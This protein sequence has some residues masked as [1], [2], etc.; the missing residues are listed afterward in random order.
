MSSFLFILRNLAAWGSFWILMVIFFEGFLQ[1][2]PNWV[3]GLAV[4]GT[5]IY[6]AIC[7]FSHTRRVKLIADRLDA[8]TLASRHRRR[9]EIPLPA[10][11]AFALVEAAIRELPYVENVEAASDSLQ[12]SAQLKRRNPYL[13][14]KHGP[15]RLGGAEGARKNLILAT[16]TP[17]ETVSSLT[18]ICEPEGGAWLDWFM[19]DDG[20]NLENAEAITRALSR[21]IAEHRKGEQAA[22]RETASEKELAVAKLNV[23]NSQFEP[24]FLYNTLASAQILT[25]SDPARADE[26]L[27]NLI[28][29]LRNSMPRTEGEMSTLALELERARAYLEIMRIRMGERLAVQIQVPEALRATPMPP[30]ML[31]TLV[32]N[33]IKHG[34][35]PLTGGG[36]VWIIA[37][38]ADGKVSVTVADNGRGFGG[39]SAG[40]GVGL[41]NVRERLKLQY[42][43]DAALNIGPNFP[44]GVAASIVLPAHA[45]SQTHAQGHHR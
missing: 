12:V 21:R 18:L 15:R 31:Q 16:V 29:Y 37:R 5:L 36:T 23:L 32:E 45:A 40:T 20:T 19:V 1:R 6:R 14:G 33:A 9:V 26:M 41:K 30:M 44:N 42:G 25:R 4:V 3:F 38:E 43:G 34:L 35:E 7:A 17:G 39:D 28:V 13:R 8:S 11:E 27:G 10:N 24:H 2:A 22:A